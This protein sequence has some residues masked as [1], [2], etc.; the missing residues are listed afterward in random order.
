MT[1]I[2]KTVRVV[3]EME[4]EIELTEDLFNGMSVE[5]YLQDFREH[6]WYVADIDDVLEYAA[7]A[8]VDGRGEQYHDGLMLLS[9]HKGETL[10]KVKYDDAVATVIEGGR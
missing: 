10:Y 9:E 4:V 7:I 6:L 8:V 3:R 5:D 1:P 2:K